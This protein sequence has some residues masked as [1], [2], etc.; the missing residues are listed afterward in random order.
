MA[1]ILFTKS[2]KR[3]K[4]LSFKFIKNGYGIPS[5]PGDYF[6]YSAIRLLILQERMD[7][8]VLYLIGIDYYCL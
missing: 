8:E 6:L 7:Y 2:K 3:D 1:M 4:V 5:S